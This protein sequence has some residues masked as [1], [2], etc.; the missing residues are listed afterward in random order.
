MLKVIALTG[1]AAKEQ[2]LL[3]CWEEPADKSG[4]SPVREKRNA[5]F[6]ND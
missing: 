4:I 5:A 2:F 6:A 3:R 1:C